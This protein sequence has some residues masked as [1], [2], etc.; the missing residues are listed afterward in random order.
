MWNAQKF[1]CGIARIATEAMSSISSA[2]SSSSASEEAAKEQY[3]RESRN[4]KRTYVTRRRI[5]GRAWQR[6]GKYLH[7]GIAQFEKEYPE[8]AKEARERAQLIKQ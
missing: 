7:E 1:V 2:Q 6:V 5:S 8:V 3:R 4:I